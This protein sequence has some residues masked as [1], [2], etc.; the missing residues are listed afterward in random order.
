MGDQHPPGLA[1]TLLTK[2]EI[3]TNIV[4]GDSTAGR[5]HWRL[6]GEAEQRWHGRHQLMTEGFRQ[7]STTGVTAGGQHHAVR[8]QRL[9]AA[10][11]EHKA[12]LR[13]NAQLLDHRLGSQLNTRCPGRRLQAFDHGLRAVLL[14]EHASIGLLHQ[15]ETPFIEPGDR[16]T[17]GEATERTAQGTAA[18]RVMGGQLL[19]IPAGVGH[20]AATAAADAHLLERLRGALQ[21]QH[22]AD[23]LLGSGDR[24]HVS[25]RTTAD[26]DQIKRA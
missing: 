1:E 5:Q 9:Q 21:H 11:L 6:Q 7:F 24:C 25:G 18:A 17:R 16:I 14:R 19:R 15:R 3:E 4:D 12:P 8:L 10:A 13:L 2:L 23:P 20:V 22:P 26:D